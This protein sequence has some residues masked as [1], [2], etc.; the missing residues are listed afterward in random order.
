[1]SFDAIVVGL[2][3]MGSATAY[4]LAARGMRVLGLEAFGR[5]HG[6]G[7]S[8]GL[9]RIIRLAYFEHPDYV[10]LLKAA[11]ELWP[12]IEA[13]TGQSLLLRTGG[14]YCGRHGSA[15][16]GGSMLSARTHGL[17]HELLAADE[18]RARIPALRL[19]DDMA[20]LYEP[21]AGLLYP[22][23][24]ID[25]HLTLAQRHGAELRFEERAAGWTRSGDG[26]EVRTDRGT[27][28]C[29]R[30]VLAAGAWLPALVPE[31]SLPL[32]VERQPLFWF[33]PAGS[34]ELLGPDRLPVYIV[35]LD[36][37]HAFYGFPLLPG[38]GAKVARHHG[39]RRTDPDSV[40]R[41]ANQDD[42]REVR[43]FVRRYLPLADGPAIDS[44]VCLYTNTPDY[45]FI[46]DLH[47]DEE[48]VVICSPCSG[49]GF[50]FSNVIGAIAADLAVNG[51]TDH[52][53]GF[54]S[55]RRFDA[56]GTGAV[57][58]RDRTDTTAVLTTAEDVL[59]SV[60]TMAIADL[61]GRLRVEPSS[62]D[63]LVAEPMT[64]PD[65][66]LGCPEP[67]LGH[68]QAVVEGYR[69]ILRSGPRVY[70]YHAGP[71]GTPVLCPSGEPDGGRE[72]VPPPGFEE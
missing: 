8:G 67:G 54:L 4:Q 51:R 53:I 68:T 43:G 66:S 38:Q 2:G 26:I 72:F 28:S 71:D 59:S 12:R 25:A 3:A 47:P 48:R 46:L 11:W 6:L 34:P 21:L 32:T 62:I 29:G 52:E 41:Q 65:G 69:V 27:Y 16:L 44:R 55:L 42:E 63:V 56:R 14:V 18:A 19:D 1:M 70:A 50:K 33:Q 60:L 30:L 57:R 61:A 7:S 39:G 13:E 49:H 58:P 23:K 20:A 64:W 15:V 45:D 31:L 37:D 9:S 35:E 5:A 17:P 22:E 36:D 40:D 10:P 24:C